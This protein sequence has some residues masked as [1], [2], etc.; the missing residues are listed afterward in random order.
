MPN[1]VSF[2]T[3][4]FTQADYTDL[5]QQPLM[6]N[7]LEY[8]SGGPHSGY[9]CPRAELLDINLTN[10]PA[11]AAGFKF[12]KGVDHLQTIFSEENSNIAKI[13]LTIDETNCRSVSRAH[14]DTDVG[15]WSSSAS[16]SRGMMF[17]GDDNTY[18]YRAEVG[19]FNDGISPGRDSAKWGGAWNFGKM[20]AVSDVDANTTVEI[21]TDNG[22]LIK[23][24]MRSQAD[25][26]LNNHRR[27]ET[28]EFDAVQTPTCQYLTNYDLGDTVMIELI[29]TESVY[30]ARIV[31]VDEVHAKNHVE[32]KI[33][34]DKPRNTGWRK[35][36]W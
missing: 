32:V 3:K 20:Y 10:T 7:A 29:T 33:R 9:V 28:V 17:K 12:V 11:F 15:W 13:S 5:W 1:N 34:T 14:L 6:D 24:E 8:E 26:N 25:D 31:E 16:V 23:S 30:N 2:R 27:E 22:V 18:K 35:G 19:R 36:Q 21:S 4:I